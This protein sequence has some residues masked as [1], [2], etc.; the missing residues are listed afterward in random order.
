MWYDALIASTETL[1]MITASS[2]AGQ[3][4]LGDILLI[5]TN[6]MYILMHFFEYYLYVCT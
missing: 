1:L 2:V 4:E 6:H 5:V 3:S